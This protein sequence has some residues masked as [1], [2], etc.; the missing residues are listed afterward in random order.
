MLMLFTY[1]SAFSTGF[2]H[3]VLINLLMTYPTEYYG[4]KT[5]RQTISGRVKIP[6]LGARENIIARNE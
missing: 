4:I 1:I 6:T 2:V 5:A 3:L